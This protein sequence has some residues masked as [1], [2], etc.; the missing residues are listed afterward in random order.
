MGL[1]ND[2]IVKFKK[3]T[4]YDLQKYL[5]GV[6]LL[7]KEHFGKIIQFY[8][9]RQKTIPAQSLKLLDGLQEESERL[10]YII[11]LN[12][13]RMD[14]TDWWDLLEVIE[15]VKVK[16]KTMQN[17]SKWARVSTT[18]ALRSTKPSITLQLRQNQTIERLAGGSLG[19][20]NEH[21]DWYDIAITNDLREE[22]YTPAGGTSLQV[23]ASGGVSFNITSIV[24]IMNQEN[25]KG[26]DIHKKISWVDNDLET[27]VGDDCFIQCC[28]TLLELRKGGNPEFV[29]HGLTTE[30]VTG[31]NYNSIAYPVLVRQITEVLGTD[32]AIDNFTIDNIERRTDGLFVELT[33]TSKSAEVF[34]INNTF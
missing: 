11:G 14:G 31:Q 10:D 24:D 3:I 19:Y 18:L 4:R 17:V 2:L 23:S 9:G 28:E 27:V 8:N 12:V 34:K 16:L 20:A 1:N 30:L 25:M 29:F 32:D 22:G 33:I 7:T 26:K 21:Q 6:E 5:L 15:D 13:N